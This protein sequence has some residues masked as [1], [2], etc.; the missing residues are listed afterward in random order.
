MR[1]FLITTLISAFVLTTNAQTN[2]VVEI[3]KVVSDIRILDGEF[4]YDVSMDGD[5]AVVGERLCDDDGLGNPLYRAGAAHVFKF[6]GTVWNHI[7]RLYASDRDANTWFGCEVSIKGDWILVTTTAEQKDENGANPL[8]GCG[9]AYMFKNN[10]SDVFIEQQKLTASV[11]FSG[12][13]FGYHADL[14][15][16]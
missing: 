13:K 1:N 8:V 15:D 9:A 6:D 11:R 2:E 5:Y 4:G 7:Q 16:G 12:D 10:G 14:A 3:Q